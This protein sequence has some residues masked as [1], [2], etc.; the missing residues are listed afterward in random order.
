M[1]WLT[2]VALAAPLLVP[3]DVSVSDSDPSEFT[4]LNPHGGTINP[5]EKVK[6]EPFGFVPYPGPLEP[7]APLKVVLSSKLN[8]AGREIG[9]IDVYLDAPPITFTGNFFLSLFLTFS[10][11][12][13][14]GEFVAAIATGS[15]P[16]QQTGFVMLDYSAPAPS[17][18]R[19]D[20]SAHMNPEADLFFKSPADVLL[21]PL[22]KLRG[23]YYIGTTTSNV[24]LDPTTPLI[25]IEMTVV[26]VPEPGTATLAG[27]GL[28]ALAG[29]AARRSLGGT[30]NLLSVLR[31]NARLPGIGN[32]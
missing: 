25:S 23:S 20:F 2:T 11:P 28:V 19:H 1:G 7:A 12:P 32:E 22:G 4:V 5:V 8:A 13:A 17:T 24:T 16:N 18:I 21:M 3:F 29:F 26:G 27:I 9:V 6:V 31:S 14:V 30:G 10:S 15:A